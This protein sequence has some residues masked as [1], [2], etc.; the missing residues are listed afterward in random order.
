[1]DEK[2]SITVQ[3]SMYKT[4]FF[5]TGLQVL[6]SWVGSWPVKTCQWQTPLLN[7]S[8][9]NCQRKKF[10]NV[11]IRCPCYKT[12]FFVTWLRCSPLGYVPG[13]LKLSSSKHPSLFSPAVIDKE[14]KLMPL[15]PGE[16]WVWAG[17]NVIKL[18]WLNFRLCPCIFPN[19]FD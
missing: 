12:F 15:I 18:F 19:E 5:I 4:F 7:I 14:N 10:Y 3:V 11:D 13:L 2:S 6:S 1:M 17:V 8:N 16:I 9:L